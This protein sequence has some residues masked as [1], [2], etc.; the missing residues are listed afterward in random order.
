MLY[1][2]SKI[3]NEKTIAYLFDNIKCKNNIH[4]IKSRP[5]GL[6]INYASS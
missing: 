1:L 5:K 6:F 4:K 3:I 2:Y